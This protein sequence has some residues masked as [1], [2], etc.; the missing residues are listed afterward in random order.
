M[1]YIKCYSLNGIKF[2][3]LMTQKKIINYFTKET[4][5][6]VFENNSIETF[7][8]YEL[9]GE[10]LNKLEPNK[11][12]DIDNKKEKKISDELEKNK[13]NKIILCALNNA[14]NKLII[15]YDDY[16][17]LIEDVSKLIIKE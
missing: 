17:A 9:E 7:N 1:S 2:T 14:E 8:L 4:L 13:N 11:K 10:P 6:V 16:Q 3:E 12:K 15:I 5:L